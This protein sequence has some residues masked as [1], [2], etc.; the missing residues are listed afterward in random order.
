MNDSKLPMGTTL[1]KAESSPCQA[2]VPAV[3]GKS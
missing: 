3:T 1:A 2:I